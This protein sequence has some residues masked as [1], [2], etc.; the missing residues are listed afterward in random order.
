MT[1]KAIFVRTALLASSVFLTCTHAYIRN[2]E[3]R[4]DWH[5]RTVVT[6]QWVWVD[7]DNSGEYSA[8]DC[9]S[10]HGDWQTA[11][12]L[13]GHNGNEETISVLPGDTNTDSRNDR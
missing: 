13:G 3:L 1:G 9:F 5:C 10:L 7:A 11:I 6:P 12:D 2:E 4:V 8:G